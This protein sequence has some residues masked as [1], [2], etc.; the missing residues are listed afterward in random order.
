MAMVSD[1]PVQISLIVTKTTRCI[2]G[3]GVD[4]SLYYKLED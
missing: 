3:H 4:D 2:T 1:K